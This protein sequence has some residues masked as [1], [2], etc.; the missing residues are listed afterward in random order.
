M[1]ENRKYFPHK[2]VLL[3]G[4]RTEEGLPLPPA[5]HINFILKGILAQAQSRYPVKICHALFMANHLHMIAVVDNPEDIPNFMRYLKTESS[6]AINRLLGRS[7]KTIWAEGY[8]SPILA[9][10]EKVIH[11]IKYIY[12]NPTRANLE[13]S[14]EE[15]PGVSTWKM[16]KDRKHVTYHPR[17]PRPLLKPLYSATLSISEQKRLVQQW[18][19]LELPKSRLEI[20]PWAWAECFDGID[21]EATRKRILSEIAEEEAYYLRQRERDK[22]QVVGATALR[23]QSMLKEYT[24][25]KRSRRVIVI[26]ED[27]EL[28]KRVIEHF[29]ALCELAAK[30]YQSWK[31]GDLKPKIPPGLFSPRVPCLVSALPI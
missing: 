15:Y 16:F 18:E 30:A 9:T 20:C 27:K 7:K 12:L 8:D 13:N 19:R 11:Y 1:P 29:K 17:V 23:R 10:P 26:S 24:P 31:R 5:H 14:I 22:R 28:R 6:H 2:S 4:T 3:L 25:E 21:I